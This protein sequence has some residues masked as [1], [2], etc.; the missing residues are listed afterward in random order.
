MRYIQRYI[1]CWAGIDG[2]R[3]GEGNPFPFIVH[4][5]PVKRAS[6]MSDARSMEEMINEGD[7]DGL[8]FVSY[9][10]GSSE[11]VPFSNLHRNYAYRR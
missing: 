11:K 2:S 8:K 10:F 3:K 7:V 5:V 4:T 1:G 9:Q 6:S